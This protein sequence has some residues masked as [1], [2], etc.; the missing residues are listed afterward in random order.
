MPDIS[1]ARLAAARRMPVLVS[2]SVADIVT[3]LPPADRFVLRVRDPDAGL[4]AGFDIGGGINSVRGTT[5]RFAARLGP[6][7]WLLVVPEGEGEMTQSA[8]KQALSGR[9]FSLVPVGHR[10]AAIAVRGRH[11]RAVLNAGI[12]LDLDNMTA[13]RDFATRTLLGK[14]EVVLA[15]IG[16]ADDFRVECWRSFAA[17]VHAFLLTAAREFV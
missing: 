3:I 15:R 4:L 11:A 5:E 2:P 16:A 7:E 12:A 9:F 14:A 17:Y 1:N 13:P 6:D 8:L 10:N